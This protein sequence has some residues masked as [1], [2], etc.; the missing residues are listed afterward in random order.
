MS[1]ATHSLKQIAYHRRIGNYQKISADFI[2]QRNIPTNAVV[3]PI[4]VN[5]INVSTVESRFLVQRSD[6]YILL[7]I[8][9]VTAL[10]VINVVAVCSS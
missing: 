1:V 3:C 4:T 5:S 7:E 8:V 9:R 10:M 6:L 2:T